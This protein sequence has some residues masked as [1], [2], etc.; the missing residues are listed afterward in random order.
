MLALVLRFGL[1]DAR[2]SRVAIGW[3]LEVPCAGDIFAVVVAKVFLCWLKKD[4][5][6]RVAAREAIEVAV[7]E[8]IR[9]EETRDDAIVT[10]YLYAQS[11]TAGLIRRGDDAMKSC[12][13]SSS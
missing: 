2:T 10:R 1:T 7:R 12:R 8:A 5:A 6:G 13:N 4:T 11:Y 3:P 9:R